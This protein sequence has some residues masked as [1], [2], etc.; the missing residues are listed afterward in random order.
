MKQVIILLVLTICCF[1]LNCGGNCPG[2]DCLNC[3]CGNNSYNISTEEYCKIGTKWDQSCCQC[4]IART[5][6]GNQNFMRH[7]HYWVVDL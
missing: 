2:N 6:K 3:Y 1:S 5:S 7:Y 4:I